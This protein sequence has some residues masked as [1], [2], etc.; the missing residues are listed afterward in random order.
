MYTIAVTRDVDLLG[1]FQRGLIAEQV[2][3]RTRQ[4]LLDTAQRFLRWIGGRWR[5]ETLSILAAD[6]DRILI[7]RE[8]FLLSD[9]EDRDARHTVRSQVNHFL[10]FL[11]NPVSQSI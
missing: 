6:E 7:L 1:R 3:W 8:R 11:A 9:C 5:V 2:P 10:S 4:V